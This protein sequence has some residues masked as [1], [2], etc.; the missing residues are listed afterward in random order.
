[1]LQALDPHLVKRHEFT[2]FNRPFKA[3]GTPARLLY[4]GTGFADKKGRHKCRPLENH[5]TQRI[6][7][8]RVRLH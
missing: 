7:Q 8:Q 6:K 5:W 2:S 3:A 4:R 1:M